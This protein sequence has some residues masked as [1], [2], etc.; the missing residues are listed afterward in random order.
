MEIKELN[1]FTEEQ[2]ENMKQLM[3]ELSDRLVLTKNDLMMVLKDDN[4]HLFV[5]VEEGQIVGSAT[6]CVFHAPS[7]TK[8]SIE[9]VVVASAYRGHHMGKRLVEHLLDVAKRYAPMEIQLTSKP[10]RV[11]ANR[12]YQTLGFKQKETNCYKMLIP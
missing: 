12:M 10:A 11:V 3:S 1:C 5:V 6:L 7:G 9:D 8:A 2:Y 4:C